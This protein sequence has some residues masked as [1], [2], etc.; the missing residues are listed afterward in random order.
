MT[1]TL[2]FPLSKRKA[3]EIL[4]ELSEDSGRV[5]ITAHASGR[6]RERCVSRPDVMCCLES[7]QI[8]EGPALEPNGSWRCTIN[9]FRAGTP[10]TVVGV[11]DFD[12]EGNYVVVV[13]TY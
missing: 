4:R 11:I 8:T 1:N 6:M 7:G 13:T 2:P 5:F 10:L 3:L 9:W 12:D